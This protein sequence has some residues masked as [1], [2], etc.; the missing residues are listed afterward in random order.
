MDKNILFWFVLKRYKHAWFVP[1]QI[2]L[3]QTSI[4]TNLDNDTMNM[5]RTAANILFTSDNTNLDEAVMN[6][7][8]LL[9]IFWLD[10]ASPINTNL[11]RGRYENVKDRSKYKLLTDCMTDRQGIYYRAPQALMNVICS[12][13]YTNYCKTDLFCV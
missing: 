13:F 10:K 2:F 7:C 5:W 12:S 3:S 11:R 8:L 9:E 1:Q 4:N 6:M